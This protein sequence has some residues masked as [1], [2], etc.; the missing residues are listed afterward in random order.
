MPPV[1][2]SSPLPIRVRRSPRASLSVRV[3]ALLAAVLV[4]GQHVLPGLH[5]STASHSICPEH[6]ELIHHDSESVEQVETPEKQ[7]ISTGSEHGEHGHCG[8]VP[9]AQTQ[10]QSPPERFALDLAP[11]S[12]QCAPSVRQSD[13]FALAI[14]LFRVAPKQS[15]PA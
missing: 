5:H 2:A 13:A 15:P 1:S 14:P 8:V 11:P 10:G 9:A 7:S 3:L 4:W 12:G 6:G